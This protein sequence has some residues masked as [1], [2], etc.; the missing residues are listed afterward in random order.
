MSDARD[1]IRGQIQ[2]LTE[3]LGTTP[4]HRFNAQRIADRQRGLALCQAQLERIERSHQSFLN[5]RAELA[6]RFYAFA[7]KGGR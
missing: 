7:A 4:P 3:E 5:R 1:R 2:S 6:A